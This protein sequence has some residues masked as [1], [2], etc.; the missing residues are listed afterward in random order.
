MSIFERHAMSVPNFEAGESNLCGLPAIRPST[1]LVRGHRKRV[2]NGAAECP[3]Q[4]VVRDT[5]MPI[6]MRR[7]GAYK[8]H[9]SGSGRQGTMTCDGGRP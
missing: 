8:G 3:K 2:P 5:L 6:A 9:G 1:P 4:S 7:P